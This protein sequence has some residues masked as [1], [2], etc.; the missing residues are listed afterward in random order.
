LRLVLEKARHDHATLSLAASATGEHAPDIFYYLR[1]LDKLKAAAWHEG[2]GDWLRLAVTGLAVCAVETG[3]FLKLS[4]HQKALDSI[5]GERTSLTALLA[6]FKR[7]DDRLLTEWT[8]ELV[9]EWIFSRYSEVAANRAVLENGKLRFDF[10]EG[11]FGL[12]LGPP[13]NAPFLPVWQGDK[14]P[15]A[16]LLLEQCGL[17][18]SGNEGWSLTAVG[19]RRVVEYT[20]V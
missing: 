9:V 3:N 14:L 6:S 10:S 13:R 8:A 20:Y 15:T 16:L 17:V 18:R 19:R 4:W 11:E 12:E 2:Q 1:E 7:F 5:A